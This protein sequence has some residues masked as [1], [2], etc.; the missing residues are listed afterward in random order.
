MAWVPLY[1]VLI[2]GIRAWGSR[3][4][5]QPDPLAY[6]GLVPTA[7]FGCEL[8]WGFG[9]GLGGLLLLFGLEGILGWLE[10]RSVPGQLVGLGLLNGLVLGLAVA[11]VEE[12]LFR[13]WLRREW[14]ADYGIPGSGWGTAVVFGV[15]HYLKPLELILQSW[16][17]CLGLVVMGW[18]LSYAI[19]Q[20]RLSGP[21]GLHGG[22]VAG[23]TWVNHLDWIRY[24]DRVPVWIT[25]LDGNPL[26]GVMGI[27]FL[28]LTGGILWGFKQLAYL[29]LTDQST[30]D[31]S[32]T[33]Q[34]TTDQGN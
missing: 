4:R 30:T 28:G 32:T 16:P 5:Q 31:Q 23:I 1:G 11:L 14:Q 3:T 24:T 6:Y 7:T 9:L 13:G 8:V 18:I 26:A 27:L 10:W 12:L 15:A 20:G 33:D 21:I 19:E 22:W 17:Q 2:W 25:G 29:K 34:S